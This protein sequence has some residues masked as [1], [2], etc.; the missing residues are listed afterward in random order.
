VK[1]IKISFGGVTYEGLGENKWPEILTAAG[2]N[3][4][5]YKLGWPLKNTML[6]TD[7]EELL[8][9]PTAANIPF[10]KLEAYNLIMEKDFSIEIEYESLYEE[11]YTFLGSSKMNREL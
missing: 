2:G 6:K 9:A 3:P 10:C 7:A 8:L 5:C 11:S 1:S 4:L